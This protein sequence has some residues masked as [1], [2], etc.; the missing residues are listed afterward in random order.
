[1]LGTPSQNHIT[2]MNPP[3]PT[4]GGDRFGKELVEALGEE[5]RQRSLVSG[6]PTVGP[7]QTG[8]TFD[9]DAG[10]Y[11]QIHDGRRVLYGN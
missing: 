4:L 6:G 1:M 2:L 7:T 10:E 3:A 8:A 11:G 5:A 9:E